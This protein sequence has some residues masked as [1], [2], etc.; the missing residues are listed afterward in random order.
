MTAGRPILF[1]LLSLFTV[2]L[3]TAC[4]ETMLHQSYKTISG[5]ASW[6]ERDPLLPDSGGTA[7][8]N[9]GRSVAISGQY[10]VVGVPLDDT[11]G[12]SKGAVYL[13]KWNSSSSKWDRKTIIYGDY[14]LSLI[15]I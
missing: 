5:A 11:H 3:F 13:F 7:D 15:H 6:K 2:S 12:S 10:A 1:L 8:D 9:F 4:E 14:D